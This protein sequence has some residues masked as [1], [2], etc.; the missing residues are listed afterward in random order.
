LRESDDATGA[1]EIA[2]SEAAR[3]V[4]EVARLVVQASAAP[5]SDRTWRD[6]WIGP[7]CQPG[8]HEDLPEGDGDRLAARGLCPLTGERGERVARIEVLDAAL[9]GVDLSRK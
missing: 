7:A 6:A 5:G 1:V 4:L 9:D 8:A 3:D 2:Q